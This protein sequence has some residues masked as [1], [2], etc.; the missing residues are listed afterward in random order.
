MLRWRETVVY[1][2]SSARNWVVTSCEFDCISPFISSW[3]T[4]GFFTTH[5]KRTEADPCA[6]GAMWAVG[7]GGAEYADGVGKE[8][9]EVGW[10]GG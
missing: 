2:R 1:T 10:R 7:F 5:L 4:S 6:Q 9:M 3:T 8:K